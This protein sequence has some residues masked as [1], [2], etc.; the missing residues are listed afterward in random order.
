[1]RYGTDAEE[2][3]AYGFALTCYRLGI[4]FLKIAVT[5]NSETTGSSFAPATVQVSMTNSAIFLQEMIKI[6]N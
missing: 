3:E 2:E 5:S 6:S 4:P 1:M